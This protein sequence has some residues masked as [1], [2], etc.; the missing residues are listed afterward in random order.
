[1]VEQIINLNDNQL[2]PKDTDLNPEDIYKCLN[3]N[4]LSDEIWKDIPGYEG[5]YQVS[6]LGRVKSLSK[7]CG[8]NPTFKIDNNILNDILERK[9]AGESIYYISKQLGISRS[10]IWK[11]IDKYNRGIS[12]RPYNYSFTR[13]L[14]IDLGSWGYTQIHLYNK[15]NDTH[16]FV[17]RLV[18]TTFIDN[19]LNKPEVNHKNGIKI[20]NRAENLEWVTAKEQMQ[21]AYQTKLCYGA[22][23]ENSWL[24]KLTETQ[25]IEILKSDLTQKE[26]SERFRISIDMVSRIKRRVS[27]KHINL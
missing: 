14:K 19:P 21:H 1:M 4:D 20:D 11:R 18:A 27:W 25:A 23:G 6:N 22:M 2:K 15:G 10:Q 26:L 7:R 24:A 5:L 9:R 16:Y 12:V 8:K 3:I 17:H 13:I